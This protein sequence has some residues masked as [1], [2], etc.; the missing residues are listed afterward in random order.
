MHALLLKTCQAL[1]LC[2]TLCTCAK[3]PL[4]GCYCSPALLE[5]PMLPHM[6]VS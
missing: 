6:I 2:W 3:P 1:A 5:K 4:Q